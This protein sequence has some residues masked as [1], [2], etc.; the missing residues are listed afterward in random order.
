MG[1]GLRHSADLGMQRTNLR[2][3]V[4]L[5][6]LAAGSALISLGAHAEA[7][8]SNWTVTSA[9]QVEKKPSWSGDPPVGIE[10]VGVI[11]AAEGSG[12]LVFGDVYPVKNLV[13]GLLRA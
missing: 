8:P 1:A 4:C 6:V 2:R 13:H 3:L 11:V 5:L 10:T 12:R 7:P 9:T